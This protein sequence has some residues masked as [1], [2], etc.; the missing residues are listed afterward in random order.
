ML[1]SNYFSPNL[2]DELKKLEF[3]LKKSQ[4]FDSKEN[5]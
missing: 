4:N 5:W 2:R 1:Q 3:Q